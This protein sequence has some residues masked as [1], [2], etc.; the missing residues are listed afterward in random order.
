MLV[1]QLSSGADG[2]LRKRMARLEAEIDDLKERVKRLGVMELAPSLFVEGV[3]LPY[4]LT[5]PKLQDVT[6]NV[7]GTNA[8]RF[9]TVTVS[10]GL[11]PGKG[12]I[13]REDSEMLR[14]IVGRYIPKVKAVITDVLRSKFTDELDSDIGSVK[15]EIALRLN[16]EVF[17]KLFPDDR[18]FRVAEVLFP[19]IILQ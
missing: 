1:K 11:L 4:Y 14:G 8:E 16:E 15:K 5:H 13:T 17:G 3:E 9:G 12:V 19:E 2:V 18:K 6:F 10:L 7:A